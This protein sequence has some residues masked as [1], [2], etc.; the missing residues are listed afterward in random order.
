MKILEIIFFCLTI[1]LPLFFII[2][3]ISK[4]K[5]FIKNKTFRKTIIAFTLITLLLNGSVTL[6]FHAINDKNIK[7]D[8]KTNENN[9]TETNDEKNYKEPDKDNKDNENKTSKGFKIEVK[10]G[11]TYIDGFMVANKTYPLP[12]TFEPLN[13]YNPV[14]KSACIDCIDKDTFEAFMKIREDAKNLG[15]KLW[16]QSGYRSFTYQDGL[17]KSYIK[18]SGKEAADTYSARPGHSEH[19]TGLAFDLNT[20]SDSFANTEEGKWVNANCYKYGFIIRYPKGK[21]NETGYKYEPWH[22]RYVG[23]DLATKLYN[24][25]DWIT[26]EDYFGITSEYAKN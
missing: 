26:L 16:I 15:L 18:R 17:Y 9:N 24:A 25:G 8:N 4:R 21:D 13:P 6:I 5:R 19:Q 23:I 2:L 20:I 12:E 22:L 7:L 3:G 11:V 14:T 1:I 10:D